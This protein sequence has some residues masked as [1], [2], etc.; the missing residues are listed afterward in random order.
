MD[1]KPLRPPTGESTPRVPDQPHQARVSIHTPEKQR[2]HHDNRPK[3]EGWRSVVTTIAV[4]L[5]APVVALL[6]TA[7]VF[8]SYQV[9]GPSMQPTLHNNDR[10]I[11]WKLARTWARI[12]GHNYIPKRGD[13]V[14][15]TKNDLDMYG[16]EPTKQ[17]VKRVIALPGERVVVKNDVIT[18]YNHD[19]PSGFQPDATL[20]YGKVIPA[21]TGDIDLVVPKGDVYVCGDN[22]GDSLDSRIFGPIPAK[23]IIGKLAVRVLPLD[24]AERF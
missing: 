11:V 18:V 4:L 2:P 21:T 9:S 23:D 5:I 22:R 19:H 17:L 1:N 8:Q 13:I 20:P 10:L 15:F 12:T 3:R 7:F 24:K 14:I 16:Q 6:L